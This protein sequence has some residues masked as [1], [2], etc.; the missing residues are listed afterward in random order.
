MKYHSS[1]LAVF[2]DEATFFP[3]WLRHYFDRGIDH[4]YLLDDRSSD[5]YMDCVREYVNSG[6]VTLKHTDESD[7]TKE[8]WRQAKIYNKYFSYALQETRWIG[9]FDLDEF[10][11]CPTHKSVADVLRVFEN[12]PQQQFI[13]DWYWF[14]SN[15]HE[16]Q[17]EDIVGSFVMRS[18]ELSKK[19]KYRESG[20][21]EEWCCKSFAK[22]EFVRRIRHHFNRYEWGGKDLFCTDGKT[23]PDFS[24]N[25]SDLGIF[26]IN[27]YVGSKKYFLDKGQ[28]GSV[29]NSD[30]HIRDSA[31][32]DMVNKNEVLDDR[33]KN[34]G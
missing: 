15:G 10:L 22:T 14:G 30:I 5:D 33:L 12:A 21:H 18:S 9:V 27:H 24:I 17:P 28:K 20:F 25:M 31:V 4:I 32:Y 1:V 11:Y 2:R 7:L 16:E 29:N 6:L 3:S 13:A 8:K 26:Y 34:Q 19:Y 23:V